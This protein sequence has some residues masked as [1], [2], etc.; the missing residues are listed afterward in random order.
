MKILLFT[1]YYSF[2]GNTYVFYRASV[3]YGLISIEAY[4]KKHGVRATIYELGIFKEEDVIR[5]GDRIRCGISD[6]QIKEI[7]YN[8]KPAIV[9]ISTMYTV[10]HQDYVD[11]IRL[12]KDYNPEIHVVAGGNHASSFPEMMLEAGADQVVVGEGEEALLSICKGDREPVVCK[13][14]ISNLDDLPLPDYEAIDFPAYYSVSNPFSM[15]TP[16]AGMQTSRG[17]PM[18]CCYCSANGVWQRKWRGRSP[19][20]IA[21]EISILKNNY[22]IREIHFLDDNMAVD[23]QRLKNICEEIIDWQLDI[24][25]ATPN[26]IPY[27]LLD[28][29]I[30]SRMKA[31]G[32]YRITFGIESGDDEM[33]KYIGKA[34]PL[35]KAKD[36]IQ[37]AN[38]IGMWTVCT[39]II[40]FPTETSTQIRK[41]IDFAKECGTDFA[42][43]FTLLPHQSSRVYKDFVRLNLIDSDDLMSELNEGGV[44]TLFFSK[45]QVKDFQ[46][47]AYNEFVSHRMWQYIKHPGLLMQ[48][49]RTFEDLA[50]LMRILLMGVGMKR[51]QGKSIK[52]SKDYIYG[53][54]QYV[55]S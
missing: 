32:C 46:R 3:P 29:E 44:R 45:E 8:E 24:K 13:E 10:F 42:C 50:Y 55:R 15:R 43:F 23:R 4:L 34:F 51:K 25:W 40:G 30:L 22:G 33:R 11:L 14:F 19:K 12:I 52:T 9:G 54:K 31:S 41:T 49:V 17:C 7:L 28:E 1:P 48:K 53:R 16:V 26:G 5:Q 27:W 47:Q 6:M 18:D 39:N 38:S 21:A 36:M 37:Y 2:T 35:S 20:Y